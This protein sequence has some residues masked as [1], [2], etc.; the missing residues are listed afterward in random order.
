MK[1]FVASSVGMEADDYSRTVE[2]EL[3]R[4]PVTCDSADCDCGQA[5]TGMGS[6][7]ATT[8]FTVRDFDISRSM[9]RELMWGTMLR[10]GWVKED[11]PEDAEWVDKLVSLHLD[12]ADTFSPGVPL[13]LNGDRLYERH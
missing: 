6:G 4:L 13:R 12:L 7:L 3:V 11:S 2:G 5:M 1:V 10:D 8:T 9:Y